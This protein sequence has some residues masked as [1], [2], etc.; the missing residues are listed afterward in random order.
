MSIPQP[1]QCLKDQCRSPLACSGWGYCREWNMLAARE[2]EEALNA[3]RERGI[4][5]PFR[6]Q[7]EV[8]V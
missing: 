8:S 4:T 5:D 3:C 6:K 1:M 7:K 2:Y